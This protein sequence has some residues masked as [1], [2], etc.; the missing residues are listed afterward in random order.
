MRCEVPPP[1]PA[2]ALDA[3]HDFVYTGDGPIQPW[4]ETHMIKPIQQSKTESMLGSQSC[5]F[6]VENAKKTSI[7]NLYLILKGMNQNLLYHSVF[8]II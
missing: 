4:F 3:N 2:K 5:L 1:L 8:P 6:L 7:S